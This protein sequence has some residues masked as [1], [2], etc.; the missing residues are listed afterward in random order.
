MTTPANENAH[1]IGDRLRFLRGKETQEEFSNR[2]GVSRASLA[3]WETGRA[4]PRRKVLGEICL[5]LGVS[6]TFLEHGEA[7]D[8][9]DLAN[10]LQLALAGKKDITA[11]EAAMVRLLRVSTPETVLAVVEAITRELEKGETL[12]LLDPL[13]AE[14]DI[15]RLYKIQAM[16]GFYERG[17]SGQNLEELIKELAK[18][19]RSD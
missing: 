18:R 1:D 9:R 17:L 11:D 19:S 12:N 15:K 5:K 2:L 14:D 16:K 7:E 4:K 6:R 13:T 3:S 10:G 8:A